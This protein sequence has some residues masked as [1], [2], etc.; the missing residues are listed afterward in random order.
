MED[1]LMYYDVGSFNNYKFV[2]DTLNNSCE[3]VR[4]EKLTGVDLRPMNSPVNLLK[5]LSMFGIDRFERYTECIVS[6]VSYGSSFSRLSFA[7]VKSKFMYNGDGF[8]TYCRNMYDEAGYGVDYFI[9][10][11]TNAFFGKKGI[12]RLLNCSHVHIGDGFVIPPHMFFYLMHLFGNK[13]LYDRQERLKRACIDVLF[14]DD[15][16]IDKSD[17]SDELVWYPY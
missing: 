16:V 10:L 9:F 5:I 2:Y 1:L 13:S 3:M 6:G 12:F 15:A 4:K 17:E 14:G 7:I 11:T 8:Y